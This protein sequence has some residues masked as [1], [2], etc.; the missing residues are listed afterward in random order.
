MVMNVQ[1]AKIYG[2]FEADQ[3][4]PP[5]AIVAMCSVRD[6]LFVATERRVYELVDGVLRPLVFVSQEEAFASSERGDTAAG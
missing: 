6:R 5:Y 3:T 2:T 4:V 1:A